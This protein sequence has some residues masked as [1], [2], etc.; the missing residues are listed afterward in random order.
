MSHQSR[1][2][3]WYACVARTID[4]ESLLVYE[5]EPAVWWMTAP[6]VVAP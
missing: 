5:F 4:A 3:M 6:R 1:P 2:F